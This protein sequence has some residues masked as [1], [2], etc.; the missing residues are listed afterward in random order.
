MRHGNSVGP[1]STRNIIHLETA[2]TDQIPDDEHP[3]VAPCVGHEALF[4]GP[5]DQ[6]ELKSEPGRAKREAQCQALCQQCTQRLECLYEAMVGNDQYG[7][8]GGMN[9]TQRRLLRRHMK[10]EGY[11]NEIPEGDEFIASLKAYQ[12][13][14]EGG[15]P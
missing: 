10:E 7:Y 4:F 8:W 2:V 14:K 6:D 15:D 3:L 5:V 13:E 9:A 12:R 1:P 11:T